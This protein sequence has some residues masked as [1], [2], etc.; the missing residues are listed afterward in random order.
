MGYLVKAAVSSLLPL[1]FLQLSNDLVN[2]F[3]ISLGST[4]AIVLRVL[5]SNL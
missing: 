2:V 3:N 5:L 4:L 1:S